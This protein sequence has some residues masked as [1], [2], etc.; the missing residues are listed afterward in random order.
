MAKKSGN[1]RS[2]SL[3]GKI[4]LAMTALAFVSVLWGLISF[5]IVFLFGGSFYPCLSSI[6]FFG[7]YH[8]LF[9]TLVV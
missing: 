4:R 7:G 6:Y 9:R 2:G 3:K 1:S 8:I 5:G